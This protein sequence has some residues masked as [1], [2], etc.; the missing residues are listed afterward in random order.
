[1]RGLSGAGDRIGIRT[2]AHEADVYEMKFDVLTEAGK[3]AWARNVTDDAEITGR[4]DFYDHVLS[5]QGELVAAGDTVGEAQ[6]DGMQLRTPGVHRNPVAV[7]FGHDGRA[8]WVA[9]PLL[10][11]G[12]P[13]GSFSQVEVRAD[14]SFVLLSIFDDV[15]TLRFGDEV[16]DVDGPGAAVVSIVSP[17]GEFI[18]SRASPNI[19]AVHAAGNSIYLV[20]HTYE[21]FGEPEQACRRTRLLRLNYD[22]ATTPVFVPQD[23]PCVEKPDWR[24]DIEVHLE[25]GKIAVAGQF[26]GEVR[27]RNLVVSN[28]GR[29]D[30]DIYYA[31]IE[32]PGEADPPPGRP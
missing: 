27:Y 17:G 32:P 18:W 3:Q 16:V 28:E 7:M 11:G 10:V 19:R 12:K 8:R 31:V 21:R 25:S 15:G 14:G 5:P 9:K 29:P 20:E 1:M 13:V 6:I 24:A 2:H 26:Q 30:E 4:P 22:G 23:V